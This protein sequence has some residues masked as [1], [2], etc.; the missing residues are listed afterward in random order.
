MLNIDENEVNSKRPAAKIFYIKKK[1]SKDKIMTELKQASLQGPIMRGFNA[2]V[3]HLGRLAFPDEL[4]KYDKRFEL[5]EHRER[6]RELFRYIFSYKNSRPSWIQISTFTE[7]PRYRIK[8]Y[9][10]KL[11]QT[12]AMTRTNGNLKISSYRQDNRNSPHDY[13]KSCKNYINFDMLHDFILAY[14][15]QYEPNSIE[16]IDQSDQS[17][18]D[19]EEQVTSLGSTIEP[20]I[21]TSLGSTIEPPI[22][23]SLG[24]ASKPPT[25]ST[26]KE[27]PLIS[28]STTTG[29]DDDPIKA[30]NR[31]ATPQTG[32]TPKTGFDELCIKLKIPKSNRPKQLLSFNELM[33]LYPFKDIQDAALYI[34]QHGELGKIGVPVSYPFSYLIK[35]M[36]EVMQILTTQREKQIAD[37][38]AEERDR[39]DKERLEAKK[40]EVEK[41]ILMPKA[42]SVKESRFTIGVIG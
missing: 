39:R 10:D 34:K 27:H 6:T 36:R 20:P 42:K 32:S 22:G 21:G 29:G 17:E 30:I 16:K 14:I 40:F 28:P 11:V 41:E 1:L 12:G 4:D 8:E 38:R 7:I 35:K 5:P 15:N 25:I 18:K 33:E 2:F 13:I 37:R 9:V 19:K 24:S 26:L 3:R 23:T 31:K